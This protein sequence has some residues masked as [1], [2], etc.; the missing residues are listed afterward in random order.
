M[1]IVFNYLNN[2]HYSIPHC[3][4][5][6]PTVSGYDLSLSII[7]STDFSNTRFCGKKTSPNRSV[8]SA[9]PGDATRRSST[10]AGTSCEPRSGPRSGP[11][12]WWRWTWQQE[13]GLPLL[14]H[15]TVGDIICDLKENLGW[16]LFQFQLQR[17]TQPISKAQSISGPVQIRGWWSPMVNDSRSEF[18]DSDCGATHGTPAL[19][20]A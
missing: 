1:I 9:A 8:G 18:R 19:H 10:Q 15:I 7:V 17:M 6:S 11:R 5:Q 12:S 2:Y 20:G 4:G 16:F 13:P 14:I 3:W